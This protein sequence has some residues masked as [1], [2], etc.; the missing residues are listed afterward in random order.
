LENIRLSASP[1]C[2]VGKDVHSLTG[3]FFVSRILTLTCHGGLPVRG[4]ELETLRR[5]I[6]IQRQLLRGGDGGQTEFLVIIAPPNTS[7][8][9]PT[10]H[11]RLFV[12]PIAKEY[13]MK[14]DFLLAGINAWRSIA[15]PHEECWVE[16][17]SG[18]TPLSSAIIGTEYLRQDL[19][20]LN[21]SQ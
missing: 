4:S 7:R 13:K 15:G 17:F 8:K 21:W 19:R 20:T 18:P 2:A 3:D 10:G 9:W 14:M 16:G 12:G 5:F 1:K 11:L 6:A